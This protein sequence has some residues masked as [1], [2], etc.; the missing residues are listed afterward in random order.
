MESKPGDLK[1]PPDRREQSI[2]EVRLGH[3]TERLEIV[4]RAV[5]ARSDPSSGRKSRGVE[6]PRHG[7]RR[8]STRKRRQ[9]DEQH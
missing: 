5:E 4:L 1:G 8:G 3:L 7:S 6:P 9:K 2:F